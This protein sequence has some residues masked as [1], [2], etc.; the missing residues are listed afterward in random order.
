MKTFYDVLEEA[1]Y[2]AQ[3]Y[4]EYTEWKMSIWNIIE[5]LRYSK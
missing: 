4:R 3:N 5:Y 2:K 1:K